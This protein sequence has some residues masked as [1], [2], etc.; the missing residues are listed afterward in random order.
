MMQLTP[1]SGNSITN[2][3]ILAGRFTSPQEQ[4]TIAVVP[5]DRIRRRAPGV[6]RLR[7]V[8]KDQGPATRSFNGLHPKSNF[9]AV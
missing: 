8:Y 7:I 6:E 2:L 4:I 5:F 9:F 1:L 3:E